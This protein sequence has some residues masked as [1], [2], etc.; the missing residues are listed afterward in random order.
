MTHY[1]KLSDEVYAR[2]VIPDVEKYVWHGTVQTARR[3]NWIVSSL[4][5][6]EVIE[7]YGDEEFKTQFIEVEL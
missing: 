5:T 2:Q 7:V 4:T 3:G 1:F 6:G